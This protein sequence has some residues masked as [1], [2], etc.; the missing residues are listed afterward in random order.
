VD[1]KEQ[2]TAKAEADSLR[3]GQ[4]KGD[5]NDKSSRWSPSG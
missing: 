4:T 5:G 1:G 3:E 2:T